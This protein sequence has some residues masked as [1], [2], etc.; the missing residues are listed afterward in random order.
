MS[1]RTGR[2]G[3]MG[4]AGR[5]GRTGRVG[6]QGMRRAFARAVFAT[7]LLFGLTVAGPASGTP[8]SAVEQQPVDEGSWSLVGD[9]GEHITAGRSLAF[10]AGHDRLRAY[11]DPDGSHVGLRVE[12]ADGGS[13]S[14][15]LAVA[16][17]TKL[18]PGTYTGATL[19]DP[20]N[21]NGPGTGPALDLT[22]AGGFCRSMDADF[23]VTKVKLGTNGWVEDFDASFDGRCDGAT[24]AA[25]GRVHLRNRPAPPVL[26]VSV[27]AARDAVVTADGLVTVHGTAT[28][29]K[30]ADLDVFGRL[31]QK[32]SA[33][34]VTSY[35]GA[36]VACVPGKPVPWRAVTDPTVSARFTTGP[37]EVSTQA[38]TTDRDLTLQISVPAVVTKLRLTRPGRPEAVAS[39]R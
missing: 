2:V 31:D 38:W 17:G 1:G 16:P 13:W 15:D 26:R 25:H 20:F 9:P 21:G 35:Y 18:T 12:A 4:S 33:G 19:Y 30:P 8:A 36:I 29:S 28:C 23:T 6:P 10:S 11:G 7:G 14:V 27:T 3:R 24:A 32:R 39:R 37:A 34:A 5:G 22:G